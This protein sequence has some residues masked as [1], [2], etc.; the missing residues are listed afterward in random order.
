MKLPKTLA[1]QQQA[2][3]AWAKKH[4]VKIIKRYFDRN[5]PKKGEPLY[6][7]Y[8]QYQK[9]RAAH[10]GKSISQSPKTTEEVC[11][12]LKGNA[13]QQQR[14]F[15]ALEQILNNI[16]EVEYITGQGYQLKKQTAIA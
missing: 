6:V 11:A 10:N 3:D 2:T 13:L 1:S 12:M 14:A 4:H 8:A 7:L 16:D 15:Q 5:K 9:H